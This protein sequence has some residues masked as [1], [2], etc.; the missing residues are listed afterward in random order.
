MI[1]YS[2]RSA[3]SENPKIH[4]FGSD[5]SQRA[6]VM[7]NVPDELPREQ[8]ARFAESDTGGMEADQCRR[9]RE[10]VGTSERPPYERPPF[11]PPQ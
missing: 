1:P 8:D 2:N 11:P 10:T 3:V 7:R 5:Q 9:R 6:S 4:R